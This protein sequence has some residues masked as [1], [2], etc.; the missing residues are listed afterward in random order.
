M[1]QRRVAGQRVRRPRVA[2]T[3][4]EWQWAAGD[5]ATLH[6]MLT[7]AMREMRV[8]TLRWAAAGAE[9]VASGLVVRLVAGSVQ[10]YTRERGEQVVP[11]AAV[12]WAQL[13]GEWAWVD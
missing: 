9:T 2:R 10:L 13:A 11:L 12:R 3:P 6:A 4:A 8:V 1:V 5:L 7:A